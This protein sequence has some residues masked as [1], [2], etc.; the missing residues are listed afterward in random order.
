[1]YSA[2]R[3]VARKVLPRQK[4]TSVINREFFSSTME[5]ISTVCQDLVSKAHANPK[6][7]FTALVATAV[8]AAFVAGVTCVTDVSFAA[9]VERG[10]LKCKQIPQLSIET[11]FIAHRST[12]VRS[13]F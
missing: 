12:L 2:Y 9:F 3:V 10:G 8:A 4:N 5:Q 6:Q 13:E 1:M 7:F 11:T